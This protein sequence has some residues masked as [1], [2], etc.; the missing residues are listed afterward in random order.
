[1]TTQSPQETEDRAYSTQLNVCINPTRKKFLECHTQ[2]IAIYWHGANSRR[3]QPN[4]CLSFPT[5][6]SL[7]ILC[8]GVSHG[9]IQSAVL[10]ASRL[11]YGLCTV[12]R[13]G[14]A[15]GFR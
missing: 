15:D 3:Q 7:P 2:W 4:E 12:R 5:L 9:P 1:M 14:H 6:H 8:S 10:A 11:S 13:P